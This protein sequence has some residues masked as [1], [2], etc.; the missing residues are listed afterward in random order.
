M[1]TERRYKEILT[2]MI[3]RRNDFK[4]KM[5]RGIKDLNT[6]I[7]NYEILLKET[8][9][10]KIKLQRENYDLNNVK[11][12]NDNK[13]KKLNKRIDE[14]TLEEENYEIQS[15]KR[16]KAMEQIK[17]FVDMINSIQQA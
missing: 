16:E 7:T 17:H 15:S 14:L 4:R 12:V 5:L 3:E 1:D 13:I 2:L 6:K 10:R 11:K 8:E 9:G